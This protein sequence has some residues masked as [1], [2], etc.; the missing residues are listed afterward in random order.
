[1]EAVGRLATEAAEDRRLGRAA[2]EQAQGAPLPAE[3]VPAEWQ[4][5]ARGQA[6]RRAPRKT[7]VPTVR[8]V[9]CRIPALCPR[10]RSFPI[11]SRSSTA[12][13]LPRRL[14]GAVGARRSE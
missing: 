8:W 12:R 2:L 11:R 1:M 10:S 7:M 14:N 5:A 3:P 4:A 6:E 9:L 13:A